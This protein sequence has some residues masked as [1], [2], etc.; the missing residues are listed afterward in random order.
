MFASVTALFTAS[1]QPI[2]LTIAGSDDGNLLKIHAWESLP[3][4]EVYDDLSDHSS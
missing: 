1:L 3:E 4:S 2:K